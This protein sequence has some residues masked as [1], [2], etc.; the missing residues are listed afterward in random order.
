MHASK[1]SRNKWYFRT[2]IY[3]ELRKSECNKCEKLCHYDPHD[4]G[5]LTC[6]GISFNNNP[7]WYVNELNSFNSNCKVSAVGNYI[8]CDTML[9]EIAAKELYWKKYASPFQYCSK[10]AFMMVVD[11]AVLEGVRIAKKHLKKAGGCEED[12]FNPEVFT[13][14]RIDR[15]QTLKQCPRYCK[16]W[17]K[18][19][20]WKLKLYYTLI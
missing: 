8:K 15:F 4:R 17:E 3:P 19:A 10:A 7:N 12:H 1:E 6:V 16:G 14:S 2:K 11:S 13:K 18:R 9:L 5:G 20:K